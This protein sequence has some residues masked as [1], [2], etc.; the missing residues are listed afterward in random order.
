[1]SLKKHSAWPPCKHFKANRSKEKKYFM[2]GGDQS[3]DGGI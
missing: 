3:E 1:M 2:V